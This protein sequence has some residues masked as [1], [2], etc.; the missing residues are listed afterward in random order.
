MSKLAVLEEVGFSIGLLK[1]ART[2]GRRPD[3][4]GEAY[5][6]LQALMKCQYFK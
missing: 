4:M 5:Q 6:E 1:G 2:R 3:R